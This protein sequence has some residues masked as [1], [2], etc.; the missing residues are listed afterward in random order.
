MARILFF[1][2]E[3][4]ISG[5][6]AMNLD[7]EGWDITFV[8]EINELFMEI[9]S[10]QFEILILDIM[11]PT[12][13]MENKYVNFTS[14]EI[15]EMDGGM[16]TGIVLA[17]KIWKFKKNA[18]ILFLSAKEQPESIDIFLSEGKKCGYLRKP[19]FPEDFSKSLND[20]LNK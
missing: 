13:E 5:A 17:Q 15:E 19:P 20:L 6:I 8:D 2:D 9:R 3:P 12:P 18:P 10:R 4:S 7:M 16:N 14:K 1:D 11:A